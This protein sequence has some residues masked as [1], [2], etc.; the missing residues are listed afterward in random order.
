MIEAI[1]TINTFWGISQVLF[2]NVFWKCLWKLI[3]LFI[4]FSNYFVHYFVFRNFF[5]NIFCNSFV[6]CLSNSN[7]EFLNNFSDKFSK[8]EEISREIAKNVFHEIFKKKHQCVSEEIVFGSYKK[9]RLKVFSLLIVEKIL[10]QFPRKKSNE[11]T[12]EFQRNCCWHLKKLYSWKNNFTNFFN[13][14]V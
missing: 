5:V 1:N 2:F 13:N 8:T 12:N 14:S 10:K 7:L 9:K 11:V 6:N 3:R 4:P